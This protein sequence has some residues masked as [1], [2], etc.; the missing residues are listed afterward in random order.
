MVMIDLG[1]YER[2]LEEQLVVE[3]AG[4]CRVAVGCRALQEH[5]EVKGFLLAGCFNTNLHVT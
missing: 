1:R 5:W 3:T 4:E 2:V